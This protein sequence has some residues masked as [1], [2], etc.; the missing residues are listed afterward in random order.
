MERAILVLR[1]NEREG[2]LKLDAPPSWK[3]FR[4]RQNVRSGVE[5]KKKIRA[6]RASREF[7]AFKETL[8]GPKM[9]EAP[10][11]KRK[12]KRK[13]AKVSSE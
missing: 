5:V 6:A 2:H 12:K 13:K 10:K 7:E 11:A 8:N 1:N 9:L 4:R 3:E